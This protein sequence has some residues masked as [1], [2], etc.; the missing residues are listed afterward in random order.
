MANG[1]THVGVGAGAGAV[2]AY[3]AA[4]Q[5]PL[6]AVILEAL[7]G[8]LG[9]VAG[10]KAPDWIDP[11]TSPNHR[12]IGHGVVPVTTVAVWYRDNLPV[13]QTKCR[14]KADEHGRLRQ[15]AQSGC[16]RLWHGLVE[17]MFRM[18]AGFLTGLLAGYLSHVGLDCVTPKSLP[19]LC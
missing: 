8:C 19:A 16:E 15:Q 4:G 6:P 3:L 5:Q 13:W 2:I 12:G 1:R 17:M 7:G 10:A 18:A 14:L 9:G 11:A